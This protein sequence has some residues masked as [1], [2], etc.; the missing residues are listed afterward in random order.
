MFIEQAAAHTFPSP[1]GAAWEADQERLPSRASFALTI[2]HAAPLGLGTSPHGLA[3]NMPPL[4]GW[5]PCV[6]LLLCFAFSSVGQTVSNP[7]LTPPDGTRLP[8]SVTITNA[9]LGS[10]IYYTTNGMVPDTN[11]A[12]YT[13]PLSFTNDTV[14]RARAFLSRQTPSDTVSATYINW[15]DTPGVACQRTVTND[16]PDLPLVTFTVSGASNVTC[17]SIVERVPAVVQ[18][19]NI[20]DNGYFTN[21]AVRWGPFTNTLAVT[22]S[23]RAA[24]LPG[25]Y[26]VDG[27]VSV[28]GAWTFG[29]SPSQVTISSAGGGSGVPTQPPQVATPVFAPVSGSSVP[30][31]V[32]ITCATASA[33]IYYTLDGSVPTTASLLYTGALYMVEA[34][35]VRAQAFTNGWTPSVASVASYGPPLPPADLA[36]TRSVS[37]NPPYAPAVSLTA[38][39]GTNAACWAV[40]EWLPLGLSVSNVTADGV[41]SVTNRVVHWG[42]FFG[43]NAQ[44]LTYQAVGLPGTYAI[45]ATWSVDGVSG[46]EGAG[47]SVVVASA[48]GGGGVPTPPS[49]VPSPVLS[50]VISTNLPITVTISCTDTQAEIRYTTDGS[51]P[52]EASALYTSALEFSTPTTLRARTFRAGYLPSL[53]VVGNYVAPGSGDG[54]DLVRA[55][56]GNSN[57][58]PA[59]SVTAT[60]HGTV[61]CYSLTES[62]A[63]GLTPYEIGQ[64]AVWNETNRTVKWGPY[65]DG[66]PRVLT[67]KVSGPSATYALGGQGSFDGNPAVVTGATAVT[68][69]L[70]TMPVVATPVITPTP[71]GV[72][73]VNVTISCVT[74]GAVIHYTLDGTQADESSPVYAG[75]IHLETTA[76]LQARA[77]RS[78]SVPSGPITVLYGDEQPASGTSLGRT[79]T[80]NSTATPLIQISVQ[81]G[82]VVKC[83]ALSEVIPAGLTPDQ[84]SG[85]GVFSAGTRTIRWGPFLDAQA[86]TV[87][88]QLS[89]PDG[90]Y[91]LSGAGSFD[92]FSVG[93]PGDRIV[94]M[95]NH[96]Y[97]AH[98]AVSNWTYAVSIVVTSRPP[99]GASCYTVEEFLPAGVTPMNLTDG[100]LWN[101]NTLTIKW[102]PFLD[103]S[104]RALRYDPV[105]AFASY[106]TS[107]RISVDGVS[108]TLVG[109]FTAGVGLPA[110]QNVSALAGNRII[111]VSWTGSGQEAGFKLYYWT[112]PNR[113]D[114]QVVSIGPGTPGFYGLAGL[115]NGT[116]YLLALTAFDPNSIESASSA[117]VSA[118]PNAAGGYYGQIA[119]DTNYYAA[120]SQPAVVTVWDADLNTN[121]TQ[122]ETVWVQVVSASDTNGIGLLLTETGND[123]GIFSSAATGTNLGF[124]FELSQPQFARLLVREGDAVWA[125]YGDG[126][127]VGQ[128]VATAQFMQFDG[129]GNGIPD[130]WERVHFGGLGIACPTCDFDRDGAT[131]LQEYVAGTDPADTNSVFKVISAR[132]MSNRSY[133]IRWSS[134]AGKSYAIE[135]STGLKAGFYELVTDVSATPPVN[136]YTDVNPPG[137]S[138]VYYRI[139]VK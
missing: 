105:G 128:R 38:T 27:S 61:G 15:P 98:A 137:S 45:H 91:T 127:P 26:P 68:V 93:T 86:R 44:V 30:A 43:T 36:L 132:P 72:F 19:T 63:A 73:P 74:T 83:Y 66:A 84:I 102:G 13:V 124:T 59:I 46:G 25:T 110:P 32:T 90:T 12:L 131:D 101:S 107:T 75:P 88:Y 92:G 121:A 56:S 50:P 111:Y 81:P 49:Q 134:V 62:V 11:A 48:T 8:V 64:D 29:S 123:T 133:E 71:N 21:G 109:D 99:V 22:V 97:L 42:P 116:N 130:W 94:I 60:P 82:A 33:A 37:T 51:L 55:V 41:F 17:F 95:D 58:L 3:I 79:V 28:D 34:S 119:F 5:L 67:Y 69:D 70:T 135:K 85:S 118:T 114:Q 77:Y 52:S 31:N 65:T 115:Q 126:L 47:R 14:L 89:G 122:A 16:P 96:P 2:Q 1:S 138:G 23:Y 18:A 6:W 24:G 54:V 39:P 7:V 113:S 80:V 125:V 100:G 57:F 53:A 87:S 108:H 112:T 9:T 76:V 35:V 117:T 78:W 20:S 136:T 106:Q 104:L 120:V 129:N 139:R 10:A 103:D 40:E 4:R